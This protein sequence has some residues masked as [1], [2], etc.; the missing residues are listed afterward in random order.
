[1]IPSRLKNRGLS[2]CALLLIFPF[3]A[4]AQQEA[5]ESPAGTKF[6]LYT[7]PGYYSTTSP[8]P[9]LLS[10]HSK[11]EVGDDLT[12]LTSRNPEQMPCR[13]IYMNRWPQ[14]LPF[15]VVTPQLKPTD[16]NSDPQWPAEY[17]DEVVRYVTANFR[18]DLTRIYVTG[19]SRGGTGAWTYASAYPQ[20]V[21]ALLPFSGR[22]DLTQACP[23]KNIPIWSF[24]GDGDDVAAPEYS[25]DM[26]NAVKACEPPGVYNPRLNIL[27][28]RN[29]NGWN[30]VYNGTSGYKIYEWLLT[31]R[32]SDDSNKAPFVNA[33]P[34]RRIKYRTA[35]L[36][37]I[38]D[39]FDSD[40][41]IANVRWTQTAGTT[42][43]L[44]ETG[45][46]LLAITDLKTGLFVFQLTGASVT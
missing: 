28:A 20:K 35:P 9:M 23:I 8:Y 2:C 6:L 45:S 27:H 1:M 16:S 12:E 24:H 26:I 3:Q 21:A 15:V 39:F 17:I 22:S 7:P 29:H 41:E 46:G 43:T 44:D 14:H 33:G 31:F 4:T 11:G 37:T 30:E 34:D 19:I 18:I 36:H 13:L 5:Y 38:G 32:K 42:L 10:L 25:I 40:G